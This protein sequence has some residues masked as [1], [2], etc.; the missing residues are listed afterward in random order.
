M[1]VSVLIRRLREGKSYADFREAWL[2]E[3]GFG[4]PTRVISAVGLEDPREV[5]TIGFTD[6]DPVEADAFL[7]RVGPQ[8]QVR[9]E[10]LEAVIEP[11]GTRGFYLQVADDDLTDQPPTA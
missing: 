1:I 8:E 10:R 5:V 11:G 4:V 7:Q 9:H 3:K 2:P 6:L